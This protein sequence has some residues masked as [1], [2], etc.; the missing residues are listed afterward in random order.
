MLLVSVLLPELLLELS[1]GAEV[2]QWDSAGAQCHSG[3]QGTG[4]WLH[5]P[6]PALEMMPWLWENDGF[7]CHGDTSGHSFNS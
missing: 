4:S 6:Q 1:L 2:V 5:F 3:V 7:V